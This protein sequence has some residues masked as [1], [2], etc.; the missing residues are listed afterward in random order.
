M[1]RRHVSRAICPATAS[2][3][4]VPELFQKEERNGYP[5]GRRRYGIVPVSWSGTLWTL[6][7]TRP[8]PALPAQGWVDGAALGGAARP[9]VV[10]PCAHQRRRVAGHPD[11]LQAGPFGLSARRWCG[12]GWAS[13]AA[14]AAVASRSTPLHWAAY[15]GNADATAA[16]LGSGADTSIKDNNEYAAPRR[17]APR[18]TAD[19]RQPQPRWPAGRRRSNA[20]EVMRRAART[21]RR[22][23]RRAAAPLAIAIASPTPASGQRLCRTAPLAVRACTRASMCRAPRARSAA[24][25][26]TLV[27][28]C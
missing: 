5:L 27:R 22:W 23:S 9:S 12:L 28:V 16:L 4:Q 14:G 26:G 2:T 1:V 11:R 20:H 13:A 25:M 17:A 8:S 18:R 7:A 15:N 19:R 6:W 3:P 24:A 10:R 21:R